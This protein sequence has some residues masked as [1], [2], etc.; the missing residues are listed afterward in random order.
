MVLLYRWIDRFNNILN[1]GFNFSSQFKIQ[2][3]DD[4]R[5]LE[6]TTLDKRKLNLFN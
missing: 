2:F 4:E 3:N 5:K 1:K 6:I